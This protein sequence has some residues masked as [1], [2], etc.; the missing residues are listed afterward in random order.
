MFK[1][2]GLRLQKCLTYVL[3]LC[4]KCIIRI[5]CKL[6]DLFPSSLELIVHV[7]LTHCLSLM[8]CTVCMQTC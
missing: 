4:L 1:N 8:F 3:D 7:P 5:T 6:G 2:K